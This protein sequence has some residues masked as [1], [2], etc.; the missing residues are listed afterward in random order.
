MSGQ[1][2]YSCSHS[3]S[4]QHMTL[5]LPSTLRSAGASTSKPTLSQDLSARQSGTS[6]STAVARCSS[7]GARV[8]AVDMVRTVVVCR[9]RRRSM[10]G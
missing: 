6:S 2:C 10:Q 3:Q 5:L 1:E 7:A 4:M 9:R 8:G